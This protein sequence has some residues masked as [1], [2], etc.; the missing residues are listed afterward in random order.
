[1]SGG[2]VVVVS[3]V[4]SLPSGT[5]KG[6]ARTATFGKVVVVDVTTAITMAVI[7]VVMY[8]LLLLIS[9]KGVLMY[10]TIWSENSE[11]VRISKR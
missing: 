1:V 9:N 3:V 2:V 10:L 11:S 5:R 6:V 7:A 8:N 4:V